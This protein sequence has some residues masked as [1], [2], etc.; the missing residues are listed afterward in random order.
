M[1]FTG[2]TI[3]VSGAAKGIGRSVAWELALKGARVVMLDAD[4]GALE[5]SLSEIR[6][7]SHDAIAFP[8]DLSDAE[9]V[10]SCAKAIA[11]E[12]PVVDGLANVAG[13]LELGS[14]ATLSDAQWQRCFATNMFA[15]MYL[16]RAMIPLLEKSAAGSIVTVGS[17]AATVARRHMAAYAASKAACHQFMRCL[18]LELAPRI[19]CNIV[20]PGSTDTEMQRQLGMSDEQRQKVLKG[21]LEDFRLGIPLN[22]IA[23]PKQVADIVLFLLSDQASHVTMET[24]TVDGGAS[25]G[26]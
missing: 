17:N 2:K 9:Q 19:R 7:I 23:D 11:A 10:A 22:R 13:V 3:V 25:L 14:I 24:I 26:L 21:S 16:S 8:C 1:K 6:R 4:Q 5:T 18:A 12:C 15:V 20:A